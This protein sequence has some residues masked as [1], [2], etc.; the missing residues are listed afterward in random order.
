MFIRF[1]DVIPGKPF[2]YICFQIYLVGQ[3]IFWSQTHLQGKLVDQFA[4]TEIG[5]DSY[6]KLAQVRTEDA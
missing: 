4:F 3:D 1:P 2:I 5:Y 6:H